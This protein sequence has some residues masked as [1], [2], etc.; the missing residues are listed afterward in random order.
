MYLTSEQHI[1][2]LQ[3]PVD[4]ARLAGVQVVQRT[5]YV[6]RPPQRVAVAVHATA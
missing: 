1:L 4:H 3:V 2:Q 6:G 5:G